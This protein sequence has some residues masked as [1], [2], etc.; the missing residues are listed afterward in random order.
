MLGDWSDWFS[1]RRR[2]AP[3]VALNCLVDIEVP[4]SDPTHYTGLT[5][6]DVSTQGMR[7]EGG[8]DQHI[9]SLISDRDR[10]WVRLRLPGM[11]TNL[12]RVQVEL[13]WSADTEKKYQTGWKFSQ[14]NS[15]TSKLISEYIEDHS[16]DI[17]EEPKE[18]D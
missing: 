16:E 9:R 13:R 3:R 11:R 18:I 15:T 10:A 8:D 2:Q 4:E 14:I 17:L 7:L 5:A 1:L 6:V 12:P